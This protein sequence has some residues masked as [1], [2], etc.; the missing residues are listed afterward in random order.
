MVLRILFNHD[1][2]AAPGRLLLPCVALARGK[3][4]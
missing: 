2:A 3:N 1:F 4:P